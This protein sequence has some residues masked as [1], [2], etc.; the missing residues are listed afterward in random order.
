MEHQL[1]MGFTVRA[2][3]GCTWV[4]PGPTE[5]PVVLLIDTAHSWLVSDGAL[6]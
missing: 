1:E 4:Q 3:R 5:S 6:S 2:S